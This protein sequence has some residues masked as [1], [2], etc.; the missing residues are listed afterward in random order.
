MIAGD[1][2]YMQNAKAS[3]SF[4]SDF[5]VTLFVPLMLRNKF[6][7]TKRKLIT[8][9]AY[10]IVNNDLSIA[11]SFP[12]YNQTKPLLPYQEMNLHKDCMNT[13]SESDMEQN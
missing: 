3:N 12:L 10:I 1:R 4:L 9:P 5:S 11:I 6:V 8:L 2:K 13:K 7:E